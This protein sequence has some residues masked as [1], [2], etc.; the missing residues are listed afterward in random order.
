VKNGLIAIRKWTTNPLAYTTKWLWRNYIGAKASESD[1]FGKRLAGYSWG[2]ANVPLSSPTA[3]LIPAYRPDKTL[4]G[5]V[6]AL[7]GAG[8]GPI[9]VVNDG[10]GPDFEPVFA[11]LRVMAGVHIVRHAINLGKGG[12]LKTGM[13]YILA[14][15][16]SVAGAVTADADGQHHPEDI[17]KVMARFARDPDALVLGTRSFAGA[18]PLRSRF[19]NGLTRRVMRFAVG[20]N[21]SD[22]QTG[23]RGVPRTL[24]ERL[25]KVTAMGYEFELEMLIAAKHQGIR[26]IEEPIRTIY[27]PGNPTS[28]FQPLRDSMRIYFVLLRFTGIALLTAILDNGLFYLLYGTTQSVLEAQAGARIVAAVFN[29]TAVRKAVFLSHERHAVVLPRYLLLLAVNTTLSYAAIHWLSGT[30][31]LGVLWAKMIAESVIFLANFALQRDF[32][33]TKRMDTP[34][35]T[36]WDDYYKQVPKTAQLT[37][38]YTTKIL[39]EALKRYGGQGKVVEIGGANSCFLDAIVREVR[40]AEYHV[41]DSNRYGLSLLDGRKDVVT[42]EADVLRLSDLGFLAD[43]VFS[44]GLI[45]HFNAEGTRR[46]IEAHFALLKPGGHAIISY[47][48]PTWLYRAARRATEALGMWKFHDERPLQRPE[49]A[50]EVARMGEIRF[51]KTLWPLVFTQHIMAIRKT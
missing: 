51:E 28:H 24:M 33:F 30:L 11:E 3:V 46:A 4:I 50:G 45:E 44:I 15:L 1:R 35:A 23:L 47:P 6:E 13:N 17:L 22:T 34:R 32:V 26:V 37:R 49:V 7:L 12:A 19:G 25:L 21:L 48:T 41:V 2:V 29:Y 40:P 39:V 9:V 38:Q 31:P 16:G 18:T 20:H 42:H 14:E 8:V 36:D 43:V 27:E 10:S 5:V